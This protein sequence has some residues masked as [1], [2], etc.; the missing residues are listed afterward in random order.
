MA[1]SSW[2]KR[3]IFRRLRAGRGSEAS[4][5]GHTPVPNRNAKDTGKAGS[6]REPHAGPAPCALPPTAATR[7]DRG[8]CETRVIQ[9]S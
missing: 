7:H 4:Y 8:A 6:T 1:G 9:A 2:E 5:F 3:A